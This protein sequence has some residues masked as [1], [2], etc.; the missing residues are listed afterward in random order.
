MGRQMEL[1]TLLAQL[2]DKQECLAVIATAWI[3][4]AYDALGYEQ[5][6]PMERDVASSSLANQM[7]FGIRAL[8]QSGY[9]FRN[10]ETSDSGVP[11]PKDVYERCEGNVAY[12]LT[13]SSGLRFDYLKAVDALIDLVKGYGL[14]LNMHPIKQAR[15]EIIETLE[16]WR[17]EM[18]DEEARKIAAEKRKRLA[19]GAAIAESIKVV[20]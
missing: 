4:Q 5:L 7:L 16:A 10:L 6:T 19:V 13:L 12:V 3:A 1:A 11:K 15:A 14:S 9:K 17:N 18:D 2:L 20:N 8:S